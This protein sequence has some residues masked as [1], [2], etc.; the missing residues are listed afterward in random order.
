MAV[1]QPRGGVDIQAERCYQPD[2]LC[3]PAKPEL[4][5]DRAGRIEV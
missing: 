2:Y 3:A 4:D 5:P 1:V